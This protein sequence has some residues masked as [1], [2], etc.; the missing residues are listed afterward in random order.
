MLH[1]FSI[2]VRR[3]RKLGVLGKTRKPRRISFPRFSTPG[4]PFCSIPKTENS[5]L[6][7]SEFSLR[8]TRTTIFLLNCVTSRILIKLRVFQHR[9][10]V[11]ALYPKQKNRRWKTSEF[12]LIIT[13]L[14]VVQNGKLGVGKPQ[15]LIKVPHSLIKIPQRKSPRFSSPSSR[16]W[17]QCKMENSEGKT[18]EKYSPGFPRF[19]RTPSFRPHHQSSVLS[20]SSFLSFS[21]CL[22]AQFGS[23]L[24]TYSIA[25]EASEL[26]LET[27]HY[28]KLRIC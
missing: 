20:G 3:G 21:A 18:S 24:M 26:F 27:K 2:R 22:I 12:D 9:D 28:L 15:S 5:E 13:F 25:R 7:T 10:F 11:F 23:W 8:F 19:L 1:Q 4:F 14:S 16:F 17:L 6:K